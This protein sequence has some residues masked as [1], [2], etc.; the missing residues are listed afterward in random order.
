M[1]R[2]AAFASISRRRFLSRSATAAA[3]CVAGGRLR[4]QS[5]A[6][7]WTMRLSTS[8]IH[9]MSL[10]IEQACQRIAALGFEAIDIWSPHAGCPH[11]DDAQNRLGP[12]GLK[13]VL[14]QNRL[15]PYAW[16]V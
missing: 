13:R 12:D 8:S 5:P 7:R 16:S 10:P 9:Y 14:E 4:A 1:T 6:S 3:A 11:L 15:K 2:N